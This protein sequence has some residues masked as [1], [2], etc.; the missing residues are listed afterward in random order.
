MGLAF[1][2]CRLTKQD[3]CFESAVAR[4]D[5]TSR[6]F[7]RKVEQVE[8]PDTALLSCHLRKMFVVHLG[9]PCLQLV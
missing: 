1:Y 4:L 3:L 8:W 6:D 9:T 2:L 5:S 7:L